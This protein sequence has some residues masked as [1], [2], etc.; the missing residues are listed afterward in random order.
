MSGNTFAGDR[1]NNVVLDADG[2]D[3]IYIAITAGSTLASGTIYGGG[4]THPNCWPGAQCSLR[5]NERWSDVFTA[6]SAGDKE[7]LYWDG[8]CRHR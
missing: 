3:S 6:I 4:G 5:S 8:C 2:N 1:A 7:L